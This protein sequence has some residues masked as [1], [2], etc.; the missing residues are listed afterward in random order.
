MLVTEL[1]VTCFEGDLTPSVLLGA[2]DYLPV[3][4]ASERQGGAGAQGRPK[5]TRKEGQRVRSRGVSL[6]CRTVSSPEP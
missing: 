5:V 4:G 1:S 2:H 6:F 3:P